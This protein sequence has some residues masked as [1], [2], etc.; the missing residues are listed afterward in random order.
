MIQLKRVQRILLI[1]FILPIVISL[2]IVLI[3]E[4]EVFAAGNWAH[5]PEKEFICLVIMEL[6]TI[7]CIPLSLRLFK[8]KRVENKL[9]DDADRSLNALLKWGSCRLN[10]L[11][12]P[13]II[14]SL[15]YYLFMNVTF[16]YMA[17]IIFLGLFFIVP[18]LERC[19]TETNL[20]GQVG[21][22]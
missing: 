5:S 18:T 19:A 20:H 2:I 10:M 15:L 22:S 12:V 13:L 9:K 21:K 8:F 17:I 11:G 6:V 3:Y 4:T 7:C 16:L 1:Q 14:N